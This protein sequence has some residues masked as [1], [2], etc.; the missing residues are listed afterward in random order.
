[1]R[2]LRRKTVDNICQNAISTV[3]FQAEN[4]LHGNMTYNDFV[5][6]VNREYYTISKVGGKKWVKIADD[7]VKVKIKQGIKEV[8][9]N[10]TK[11]GDK[12]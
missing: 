7:V 11:K 5:G 8:D 3:L 4:F 1:M 10:V 9:T 2:I 12:K 6:V